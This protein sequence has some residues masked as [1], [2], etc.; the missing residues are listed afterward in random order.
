MLQWNDGSWERGASG[1]TT[2]SAGA[3]TRRPGAAA[4]ACY[5]SRRHG[6]VRLEVR[7]APSALKAGPLTAFVH[8]LRRTRDLGL[9][10]RARRA[11]ACSAV[12]HARTGLPEHAVAGPRPE[13]I[14]VYA[15]DSGDH[16]PAASRVF[17]NGKDVAPTNPRS[18]RCSW[19]RRCGCSCVAPVTRTSRRFWKWIRCRS[20]DD[21]SRG[22]RARRLGRG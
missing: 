12:G 10:R 6:S 4:S 9:R 20:A 17:L 21:A 19:R 2:S 15:S 3:P 14:T 18:M 13:I 16:T 8:A 22:R 7:A 11:A 1:A 5:P